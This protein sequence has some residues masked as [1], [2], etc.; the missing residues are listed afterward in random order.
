MLHDIS[1][2]PRA[3]EPG[4]QCLGSRERA[5][6]TAIARAA[7]PAGRWFAG[8][9]ARAVE[10]V[11]HFLALSP[12]SVARAYRA[13]LLALD[14]WAMAR[15]RAPLAS[16]PTETV[17]SLLERWRSGDVARRTVVRMLTAPLKI[18]H[19][20]DPKM[21]EDVG[22]RFGALPTKPERPRWMQERVTPASQ[23]DGDETIEC[24]VVVIG[25]GAG[26]AVVAKE[27]AE[28][29]HAVVLLEEGD[30]H[31]R[32]DFTGHATEMQRKLYR[33]MGATLSVG[34]AVIP[35]PL[36]RTVGGSTAI[37][38]GTCY[39]TPA[40]V[41]SHWV[42]E[43]GLDDLSPE[44]MA[45]WFDR[46]ESVLGVAPA[47]P[48]Y[49][50][51]VARV[52][53]RGC[54][55]LGYAH[56]P[57][58]R[59]A[60]ECDGQGVCCFGCPSDAKRSTNVSY[61]PMALRAGATLFTG[62]RADRILVDRGRAVGVLAH[63]RGADGETRTLTVRA[64]AVVV[65]CGSLLTPLL[66]EGSGVGTSS[67]QLG[68]N[69]SIHPALAVMA[70]FDE[71]LDGGNAI[72]QGYAIEQFH[73]EGILFEGAFAPLDLAAASMTML[74]PKFVELLEGYDRLACFGVMIEDVSRGRVRRGPGGRPLITY[75]LLDHDVARLKR[76]VEILSR[77]YFAAGA[78]KVFPLVHG[79]D[80]LSSVDDVE[81][82][83]RA[84]LKA[85][86]FE[87][88]AYHPLGTARMGRDPKKS[89]VGPDHQTHDTRGLYVAD[90]SV[91]PSSPAVNPQ[92]TIMALATRAADEIGKALA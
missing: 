17:L 50:G 49:L 79:F 10:K 80:E 64:N 9:G 15:H 45:P 55:A 26:G 38:S 90:G 56:Q 67:G 19:Y 89:V 3:K 81:R 8:G 46:V 25:T 29:G 18:A 58:R 72:P 41:L 6:L 14:A 88:T 69:L 86:D 65:A 60:P 53:A 11:D 27:L 78:S 42:S 52:I 75:S 68:R 92:V 5:A 61:V 83:R 82:L 20:N 57:L 85:R 34:N 30:Y 91:V 40:R 37:N 66:L 32:S 16:L 76:A 62:V 63:G 23:L 22:C 44:K 7:M 35:I 24:E 33:D 12:P 4:P 36:G 1:A 74:G 73:D 39:R 13:M 59:N 48:R 77:V 47:E 21:Y 2:G 31:T 51:G 28:R 84:R 87:I 54:D 71:K 43:F 70:M